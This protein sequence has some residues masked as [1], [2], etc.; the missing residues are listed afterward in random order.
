MSSGEVH[1][2]FIDATG[3]GIRD[4]PSGYS[5]HQIP[6]SKGYMHLSIPSKETWLFKEI[7]KRKQKSEN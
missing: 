5:E 1:D 2:F 6:T 7:E 3:S 4:I